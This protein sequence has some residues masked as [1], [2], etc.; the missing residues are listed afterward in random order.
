MLSLFLVTFAL[1]LKSFVKLNRA[2]RLSQQ[3]IML[4][5]RTPATP[6]HVFFSKN[7]V[8]TLYTTNDSPSSMEVRAHRIGYSARVKY[9]NKGEH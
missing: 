7:T 9:F 4:V 3:E 8:N 5:C 1:S 2:P 6:V